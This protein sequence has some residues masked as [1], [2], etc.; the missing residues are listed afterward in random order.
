MIIISVI[1]CWTLVAS[2]LTEAAARERAVLNTTK[3]IFSARPDKEQ[4][5][6]IA[7]ADA[8]Q[9]ESIAIN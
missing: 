2:A 8:P 7:T 4:Q 5:F 1:G 6:G 9:I 3:L